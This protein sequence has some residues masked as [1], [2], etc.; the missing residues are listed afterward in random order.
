MKKILMSMALMA[1]L[2]NV[3]AATKT[4]ETTPAD[5]SCPTWNEWHDLQVNAVNRFKLHTQFFAYENEALA[6][7]DEKANSKNFLSLHGTWKFKWVRHANERPTDFYLSL[8]HI[9]EP[10]RLL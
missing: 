9:S 10:T 2:L 1:L 7:K 3:N 6:M 4:N 8:I 5:G